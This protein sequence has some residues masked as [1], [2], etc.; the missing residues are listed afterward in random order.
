MLDKS[1]VARVTT[2]D[3]SLS[4][5]KLRLKDVGNCVDLRLGREV[6]ER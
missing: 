4:L 3:S 6:E 1:S 5:A 2:P